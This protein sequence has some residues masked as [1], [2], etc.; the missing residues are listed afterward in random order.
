MQGLYQREYGGER[1][2]KLIELAARIEQEV[3]QNADFVKNPRKE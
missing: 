1:V 3:E 2:M